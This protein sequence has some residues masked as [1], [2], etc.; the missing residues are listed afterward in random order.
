MPANFIY[1]AYNLVQVIHVTDFLDRLDIVLLT[2][3]RSS[4][5]N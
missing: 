1:P 5:A 3:Y 2:M 4:L